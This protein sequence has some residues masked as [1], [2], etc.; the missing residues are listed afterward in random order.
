MRFL[1]SINLLQ[2]SNYMTY[3]NLS[4][5]GENQPSMLVEI[6][7]ALK[8]F[9]QPAINCTF[10]HFTPY[11]L[12]SFLF[13]SLTLMNSHISRTGLEMYEMALLWTDL[14]L[15]AQQRTKLLQKSNQLSCFHKTFE[16]CEMFYFLLLF[17]QEK[18]KQFTQEIRGKR[19]SFYLLFFVQFISFMCNVCV[20]CGLVKCH[21][22]RRALGVLPFPAFSSA[23][24]KIIHISSQY[25][26]QPYR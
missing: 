10:L 19:C 4:A 24:Q 8:P 26:T 20:L 9:L 22:I 14:S 13:L 18:K 6:F 11:K 2:S 15:L 16:F 12:P 3:H 25:T 21:E 1:S 17:R 23:I 5:F 7:F